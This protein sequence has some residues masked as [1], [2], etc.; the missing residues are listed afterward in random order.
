MPQ[1]TQ[2]IK[3]YSSWQTSKLLAEAQRYDELIEE[4]DERLT[5]NSSDELD[6]NLDI[7]DA[8]YD[9]LKRRNIRDFVTSMTICIWPDNTWCHKEELDEYSWKSDDWQALLLNQD[10]PD[11]SIDGII[12]MFNRTLTLTLIRPENINIEQA[13][14]LQYLN[15]KLVK[16]IPV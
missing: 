13:N 3:N 5:T 11:D 1:T 7:R 12:E 2:T 15:E 9:E 14:E 4:N 10:V 8:I 6:I 16:V